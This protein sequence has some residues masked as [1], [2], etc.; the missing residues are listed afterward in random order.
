MIR[1]PSG[2]TFYVRICHDYPSPF[3][4]LDGSARQE[5]FILESVLSLKLL[6][7]PNHEQTVFNVEEIVV[8]V[9][10]I[11][12]NVQEIVSD[13]IEIV[14]NVIKI[15]FNVIEV[16]FKVIEIVFNVIELRGNL[17]G[18]EVDDSFTAGR[19]VKIV[20]Q[21]ICIHVPE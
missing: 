13:V 2:G 18:P 8:N 17:A 11:D 4:P 3:D 1:A 9:R 5:V 14:F 10:Q 16:V 20:N 12:F 19:F 21:R 15:V 6:R 7:Y